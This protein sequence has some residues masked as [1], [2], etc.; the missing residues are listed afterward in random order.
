[1]AKE[2]KDETEEKKPRKKAIVDDLAD[3]DA[4]IKKAYGAG[5]LCKASEGK[6]LHVDRLRTGI[7]AFDMVTGGG[8]PVRKITTLIG[9]QSSAKSTS[10]ALIAAAFQRHCRNCRLLCTACTCKA[11]PSPMRVVWFDAEGAWSNEWAESLGVQLELTRVIRVESAEQGID[12]ADVLLR[13]GKV[14]LLIVDSIAH[15]TPSAEIEESM[16]KNQIASQAKLV[17]KA[18][19]KWVAS[20]SSYGVDTTKGPTIVLINQIRHKA[21]LVFGNPETRPGGMGQ[22]FASS[23]ELRFEPGKFHYLDPEGN[24]VKA[25]DKILDGMAP[26]WMDVSFESIK[27]R[28]FAPKIGGSFRLFLS[29]SATRHKGD[30]TE[31]DQLL[32]HG[33]VHNV[34]KQDGRS[35]Q[36][37]KLEASSKEEFQQLLAND[38]EALEGL[39]D[40][41]LSVMLA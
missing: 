28:T 13:S 15:L 6:A 19:R 8:I 34:I 33:K 39:K 35:W 41:L 22:Q 4:E 1:M 31:I 40:T 5:A 3:V 36:F 26:A 16:E 24:E 20:L 12:I 30:V 11:G 23:I 17:N 10:A 27:N 32:E 29:N 38:R 25:K 21:G 2:D 18:L 37:G 7:F 14:D 9:M